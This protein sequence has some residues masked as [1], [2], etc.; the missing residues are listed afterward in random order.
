MER[1]S[2]GKRVPC[3]CLSF[4]CRSDFYVDASGEELQGKLVSPATRT[5]HRKRD[6]ERAMPK[7]QCQ[8]STD[9]VC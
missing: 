2:A 7:S 5:R 9:E 8:H 4:G 3:A 6:E 1:D